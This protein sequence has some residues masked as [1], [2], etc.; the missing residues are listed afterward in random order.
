MEIRYFIDPETSLPHIYHHDVTEEDV[1]DASVG[2]LRIALGEKARVSPLDK[3]RRDGIFVSSMS[4]IRFP[5][6]SSSSQHTRSA[7]GR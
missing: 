4:L 5:T 1:E 7:G 2:L 6:R 3:P